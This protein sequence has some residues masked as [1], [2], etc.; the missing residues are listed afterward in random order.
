MYV[1]TCNYENE[2][3]IHGMKLNRNEMC[4]VATQVNCAT[5][6]Q[7]KKSEQMNLHKPQKLL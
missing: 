1:W 2:F 4:T 6:L 5:E 3:A 7:T